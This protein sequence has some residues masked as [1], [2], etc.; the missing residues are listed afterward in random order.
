MLDSPELSIS[1]VH[2]QVMFTTNV[3][4]VLGSSTS[5][6]VTAGCGLRPGEKI[7]YLY[8][9]VMSQNTKQGTLKRRGSVVNGLA[10]RSHAAKCAELCGLSRSIVERAQYV[11]WSH[12]SLV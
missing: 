7:T 5:D 12:R 2:M 1:F 3:G 10:R 8:R 6:D 11:R 9:C 4:Q